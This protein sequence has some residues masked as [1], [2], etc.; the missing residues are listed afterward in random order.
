MPLIKEGKVPY[1]MRP[2]YRPSTK[3]PKCPHDFPPER[4]AAKTMGVSAIWQCAKCGAKRY[5][6]ASYTA[7]GAAAYEWSPLW[8]RYLPIFFNPITGLMVIAALCKIFS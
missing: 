5:L 2:D 1:Y 3:P 7:E 4:E 6:R 8:M